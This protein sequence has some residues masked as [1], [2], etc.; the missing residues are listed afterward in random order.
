MDVRVMQIYEQPSVGSIIITPTVA[1]HEFY[2]RVQYFDERH[3][4]L[5]AAN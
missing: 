2:L 5:F 3:L 1:Q 4:K